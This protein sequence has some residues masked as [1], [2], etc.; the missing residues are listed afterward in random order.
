MKKTDFYCSIHLFYETTE[1]HA[2]YCFLI[3]NMHTRASV[4]HCGNVFMKVGFSTV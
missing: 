2:F 4:G 3:W 1:K